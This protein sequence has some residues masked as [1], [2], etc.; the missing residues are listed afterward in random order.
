[1]VLDFIKSLFGQVAEESVEEVVE[2]GDVSDGVVDGVS[3]VLG[4]AHENVRDDLDDAR[5]V[6]FEDWADYENAESLRRGIR[7]ID[8]DVLVLNGDVVVAQAA[9]RRL[10]RRHEVT[11]DS[12]VARLPGVQEGDTAVRSDERG[13]VVEYGLVPGP[14]HAGMG[15]VDENHL[16]RARAWL[17]ENRREWYPGLYTAVETLAIT[18]TETQ[19][20]EINSPRDVATARRRFPLAPADELDAET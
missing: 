3:V 13:R 9:V 11:G 10:V 19:H 6:I 12:V 8:D 17:G 2:G 15:I 5:A 7:G 14:Q 18:I 1:M 16:D 4:Y 20:V